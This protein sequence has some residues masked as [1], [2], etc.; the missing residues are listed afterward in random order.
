MNKWIC[1]TDQSHVF[2]EPTADLFCPKCPVYTV[3]LM[4]LE[5]FFFLQIAP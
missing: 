3:V 4:R 2:N 1:S 5:N